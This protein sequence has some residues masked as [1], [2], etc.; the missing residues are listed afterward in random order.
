MVE[1]SVSR[2]V[3]LKGFLG[4]IVAKPVWMNLLHPIASLSKVISVMIPLAIVL[5]KS[6]FKF[7]P[8]ASNREGLVSL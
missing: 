3:L 2:T 1:E 8:N 5:S 4:A 7:R 6:M